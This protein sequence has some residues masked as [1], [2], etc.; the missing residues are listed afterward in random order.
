MHADSAKS[1][2]RRCASQGA[3]AR[4]CT[5]V[6]GALFTLA[7]LEKSLAPGDSIRMTVAAA[8]EVGVPLTDIQAQR[9]VVIL[10]LLELTFGALLLSGLFAASSARGVMVFLIAMTA[11]IVLVGV[12]D[13]QSACGCGMRWLMLGHDVGPWGSVARNALLFIPAAIVARGMPRFVSP[14]LEPNPEE[15]RA[16]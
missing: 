3:L 12:H 6:L 1:Q 9:I 14:E 10:C 7:A 2:N 13:P 11:A 8:H 5:V 15:D 4:S 16:S